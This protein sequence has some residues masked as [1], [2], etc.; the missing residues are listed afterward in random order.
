M[1]GQQGP[2]IV[3][4]CRLYRARPSPILTRRASEGPK[5][6][7]RLRFGLVW[8][9]SFPTARGI[10]CRMKLLFRFFYGMR[11]RFHENS[12]LVGERRATE[13]SG[14]CVTGSSMSWMTN[15]GSSDEGA[16]AAAPF[17]AR[18]APSEPRAALRIVTTR[19]HTKSIAEFV[20]S[21]LMLSPSHCRSCVRRVAQGGVP[22][23]LATVIARTMPR[24][25]GAATAPI[26]GMES[27]G[28]MSLVQSIRRLMSESSKNGLTRDARR[29]SKR[30]PVRVEGL[31]GR[32]LLSH[33]LTDFFPV[34]PP[35]ELSFFSA[36]DRAGSASVRGRTKRPSGQ[37]SRGGGRRW[38]HHSLRRSSRS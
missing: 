9:V 25:A 29:P 16:R 3:V 28:M 13:L 34:T 20:R 5:Q 30:F 11:V 36:A 21:R 35:P 7:P 1:A 22:S 24:C 15:G 10:D 23:V 37:R 27:E 17:F 18:S 31:E 26:Y 8:N 6:F 2:Q 4:R 19:A 12:V 33:G 14:E 32:T 38:S